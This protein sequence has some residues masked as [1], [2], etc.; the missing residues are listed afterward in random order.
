[1]TASN[2]TSSG[3]RIDW[4]TDEPADS[5]VQY[6]TTTAYGLTTPLDSTFRTNHSQP[7]TGLQPATLY[8]Y[9]VLSRDAAGNLAS[10]SDGT[11]TTLALN[12]GL[13]SHWTLDEGS[14]LTAAD[15]SG[16]GHTGTLV[17]G[18]T[19]TTAGRLGGALSFDGVND[20]VEIP[21]SPAL[22]SPSTI[23]LAAWIN[24][25]DPGNPNVAQMIV[26]KYSGAAGG[27]YMLRINGAG[28]LRFR[29]GGTQ[30]TT[31]PV[32]SSPNTWYHVAGTY[33]G[34]QLVIYL[35]GAVVLSQAWSGSEPDNGVNPTLGRNLD[36]GAPFNGLLDDVR[37]YNRALSAAEI[38][39]LAAPATQSGRW[40]GVFNWPL[41]A[42]HMMMLPNGK[43]LVLDG[44]PVHCGASAQLWDPIVNS[45]SP[46]SNLDSDLFCSGHTLLADGRVLIAGGHANYFVGLKDVNIFDPLSQTWMATPHPMMEYGRWYPTATS[47]PDGRVLVVS[48]ATTCKNCQ[49]PHPE[50]Y[51]PQTN[52]VSKLANAPFIMDNY[53]FMFVLPD[54]RVLEAGALESAIG[55]P[56]RVLD[57][58]TQTW[59]TVDASI[60]SSGS[61]VMYQPG[62]VMKV[63]ANTYVLDM[64]V[65]SPAWQQTASPT[66][67]RVF[68]NLTLLPD[69]TTLVTGGI[70]PLVPPVPPTPIYG[71]EL[72]SPV[73][74]TWTRM[75]SMSQTR[76]YHST[77]LLLAD[78][79]VVS[80]GGGRN[81]GQT[82]FLNA[83]FFSPPYLFKGPRPTISTA[84]TTAT[85]A[86]NFNVAT[87]D[88][89]SIAR[90][91]LIRLGSV[92]HGFDENQRF[93][94]LAFQSNA[95]SLTVTGPAN[96][97]VA[98]PGNYMLFILN[99][100]GVPS[101]ASIIRF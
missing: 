15:A 55:T 86:T 38:Q 90:V 34:S 71:A 32:L 12:P 8:H 31:G 17:N 49:A 52:A 5:Q 22:G 68:H 23:T 48:G 60:L 97:N 58:P 59:T 18:P 41:V 29:A 64:N 101:V 75:A 26:G 4:T 92:T 84:P 33:N 1:V 80:A 89:A 43:I 54:G 20:Y 61:A 78:G 3:A 39:D 77:A 65:P 79:R 2:V 19:W 37:L 69:G 25:R 98:P 35:N 63:G 30:V 24:P 27:P 9:Q 14:G 44:P 81:P 76:Q 70:D 50:I 57:I 11:F 99:S 74:K 67:P 73:T 46:V 94:E 53:P 47:L 40:S 36:G 51:D 95:G 16:N 10:S 85:Y 28:R 42:V 7:L 21:N 82:D 88:A 72:W 100:A 45:F 62:K 13:V 66:F 56:T 93:L 87:P 6:G 96:A 91:T 83:E